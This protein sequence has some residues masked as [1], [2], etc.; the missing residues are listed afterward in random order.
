VAG[1][2][3][4]VLAGGAVDRAHIPQERGGA[5]GGVVACSW[6]GVELVNTIDPAISSKTRDL[7][8]TEN[9]PCAIF[10]LQTN[11]CASFTDPFTGQPG[12]RSLYIENW[13]FLTC[14]NA[15]CGCT[16]KLHKNELQHVAT[17]VPDFC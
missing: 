14:R 17:L 11:Q 13:G 15:L 7:E 1:I 5:P 6:E 12:P 3:V 4:P 2:R 16:D 8:I 9:F 10:Q